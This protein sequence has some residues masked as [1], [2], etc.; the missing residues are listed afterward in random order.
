MSAKTSNTI[1]IVALSAISITLFIL[2]MRDRKV[3]NRVLAADVIDKY[4]GRPI[5]DRKNVKQDDY[6]FPWWFAISQNKPTFFHGGNV[7]STKTGN[8]IQA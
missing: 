1:A 4:V 5:I 6:L 3:F 7:F 8:F 2:W